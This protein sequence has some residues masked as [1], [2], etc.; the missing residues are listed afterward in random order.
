MDEVTRTGYMQ[1]HNLS[2]NG[3]TESTRY[4]V[5]VNYM[6]QDGVVKNNA[7][8]R[9]SA[10]VNLDQDINKMLTV[11][12]SASYAQ[13]KYDNVP[14]GDKVDQNAGVLTAAIQANPST[15]VYDENG[16]YYIDPARSSIPNAV[17]LLEIKDNTVKD[18]IMGFCLCIVKT[19]G[20]VRTE[21]A[22]GSRPP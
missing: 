12:L 8:T 15:P 4:L 7:A 22:V 17:S 21:S 9:L 2:I 13:N 18:R 16:D 10:R 3:G 20:R 1:Q 6:H 19:F 5:S 14:L 11:G